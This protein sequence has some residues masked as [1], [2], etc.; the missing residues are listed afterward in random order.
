MLSN[1]LQQLEP[2]DCQLLVLIFEHIDDGML[3][4]IA[5]ADKFNLAIAF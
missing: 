5:K 3:V 2:T 4:E 1:P